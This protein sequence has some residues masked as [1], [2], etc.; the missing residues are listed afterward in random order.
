MAA[1]GDF[2]VAFC[3]CCR[4]GRRGRRSAR[5]LRSPSCDYVK[6][7]TR[8]RVRIRFQT[9]SAGSANERWDID[10]L[11]K[12]TLDAMGLVFGVREWR[13]PD[14]A[15]DDRVDELEASKRTV[16]TAAE[17]GADITVWAIDSGIHTR[18]GHDD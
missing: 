7:S 2:V 14:Q 5:R 13:G 11:V 12:P 10:D 6:E 4:S 1:A 17:C 9:L 3:W 16:A 8:Y 18:Q 15:A